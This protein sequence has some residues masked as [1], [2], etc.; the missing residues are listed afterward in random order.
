[1]LDTASTSYLFIYLP[2]TPKVSWHVAFDV[3][4]PLFV[5]VAGD[6]HRKP[7]DDLEPKNEL[8]DGGKKSLSCYSD[9]DIRWVFTA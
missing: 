9:L 7:I 6:V 1:M 4:T 5:Q 3:I 8:T 2:W